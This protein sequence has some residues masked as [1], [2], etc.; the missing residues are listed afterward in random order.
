MCLLLCFDEE[1]GVWRVDMLHK[2]RDDEYRFMNYGMNYEMIYGMK[3]GMNYG[4]MGSKCRQ[5]V[6]RFYIQNI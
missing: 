4:S 6:A 3:Y 5:E 1:E 2:T